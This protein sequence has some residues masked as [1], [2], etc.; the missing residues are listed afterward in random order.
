MSHQTNP[1]ETP[2]VPLAVDSLDL[3]RYGATFGE[4]F[5]LFFLKYGTF[6]GRA[7]RSEYW[8]VMLLNVLVTSAC[9]ALMVVGGANL[10][11]SGGTELPDAA[12]P[13]LLAWLTYWLVTFLP[14]LALGMRRFHD[15][16]FEG[17]SYFV[18]W[19][20]YV[21][22][23]IALVLATMPSKPE[24]ARFDPDRSWPSA[25]RTP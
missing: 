15:A 1:D 6:E 8:W 7:S 10:L 22:L 18:C 23:P 9:A 21:G 2:A 14:N 17:E 5:K 19:L 11:D 24:G 16:N 25:K 3:P 13:W 4:A 12:F 20:P